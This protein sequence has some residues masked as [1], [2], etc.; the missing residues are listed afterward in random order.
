MR[1]SGGQFDLQDEVYVVGQYAVSNLN[2][3]SPL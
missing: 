2:A 1:P 3:T